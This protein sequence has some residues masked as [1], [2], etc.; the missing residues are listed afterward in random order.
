[1]TSGQPSTNETPSPHR[2]VA[3]AD[4]R[5]PKDESPV[6]RLLRSGGE[7]VSGVCNVIAA[8]CLL[9]ITAVNLI[10]VTARYLFTNP[11]AWAEELMIFLMILIVFAGCVTATWQQMHIHID[12]LV[13]AVKPRTRAI[14]GVIVT[15]V[16]IAS[17]VL[18]DR[19]GFSIVE[20]LFRFD[21]RSLAL[22]APLWVPQ[23]FVAVGLLIVIILMAVRLIV[24]RRDKHDTEQ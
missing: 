1:M 12:I 2:G 21:Q 5:A 10:N 17:L 18:I 11:F 20:R 23:S 19:A 15:L 9:A 7:E 4:L 3:P 22:E 24:P 13:G 8:I 6:R 16:G 14:L